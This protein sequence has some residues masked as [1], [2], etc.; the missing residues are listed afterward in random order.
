MD[1]F[2]QA[3]EGWHDFY[4]VIGT[5]A[6]TLMGLLFLSLSL[7]ADVITRKTNV[8]LRVLAAQTFTSFICVLMFAVLF[9][10]PRQGPQGLGLPLLGIDGMGLYT[11]VR[12][13]LDMRHNRPRTWGR[14]SLA[15]RF[16]IPTLCFVTLMIIAVSVLL[17]QTSGLYWLVPVM[18]LL[19]WD[20]SLNAWDLLLRLREPPKES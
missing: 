9:L 6:A 7:N 13:F 3:V 14:G 15:R 18:I 2:T 17:G 19:I 20:A 16:A 10:I 4:I 11:T 1:T 12:R 8:D 5:A